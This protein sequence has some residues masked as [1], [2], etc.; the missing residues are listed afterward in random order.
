MRQNVSNCKQISHRLSKDNGNILYLNR[1]GKRSC[2]D[3]GVPDKGK[4]M[5]LY[6]S[7]HVIYISNYV[8]LAFLCSPCIFMLHRN[9]QKAKN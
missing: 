9:V 6:A 2:P 7:R 3:I 1:M 4:I 5:H 8:L